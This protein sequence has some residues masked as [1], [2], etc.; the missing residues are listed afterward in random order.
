[1]TDTAP[2]I[3]V[4]MEINILKIP[5][6]QDV[7]VV[8]KRAPVGKNAV[9]LMLEAL[10]PG[11]FES[12]ELEHPVIEALVAN[13]GQINLLGKE[14]LLRLIVSEVE[15]LM[16]ATAVLNIELHTKFTKTT[17]MT[18]GHDESR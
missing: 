6:C 4:Q 3:S 13:K 14:N 12:I 1:M 5:P 18:V 7:I 10:A 17:S 2:N 9:E 8:G 16:D 11:I 15:N